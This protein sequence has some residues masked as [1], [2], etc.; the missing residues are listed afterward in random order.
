MFQQGRILIRK[1]NLLT[2][3][4]LPDVARSANALGVPV[5]VFYDSNAADQWE[6]PQQYRDNVA[7]LPF[8]DHSVA[9]RTLLGTKWKTEVKWMYVVHGGPHLRRKLRLSRTRYLSHLMIESQGTNIDHVRVIG[10]P[11]AAGDGV[12]LTQR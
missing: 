11:E 2:D 8:D 3:I 6:L 9:L 7:G 4:V 12:A 1:G 5:R 10:L